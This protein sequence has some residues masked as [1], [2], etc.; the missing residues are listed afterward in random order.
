MLHFK[1]H[2]RNG[3]VLLGGL[4]GGGG[5]SLSIALIRLSSFCLFCSRSFRTCWKNQRSIIREF[6]SSRCLHYKQSQSS[7]YISLVHLLTSQFSYSSRDILSL[8]SFMYCSSSSL[9]F[10]SLR[11]I[12]I[13]SWTTSFFFSCLP[14]F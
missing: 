13:F 7:H 5:L 8:S 12:W 14:S 3:I 2:F 10:T 4:H 11:S 9:S 1:C 6:N